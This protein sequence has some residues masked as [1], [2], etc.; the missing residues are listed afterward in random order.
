M[1]ILEITAVPFTQFHVGGGERAPSELMIELSGKEDVIGC[2][3]MMPGDTF[4]FDRHFTVPAT[5]IS[6]PPFVSIHNPLPNLHSIGSIGEFL[7][8]NGDNIEFIHIHNLRTA[9][10]TTW[11][12]LSGLMKSSYHYKII[13]TDHLARFFPFPKLT[14]QFVDYYAA[15]SKV[16][17]HQLQSYAKRPSMILPPAVSQSYVAKCKFLTFEERVID[18]LFF[19]RIL[20]QKRPEII[21][22]FTEELVNR[23]HRDIAVVIAGKDDD[24]K[25]LHDIDKMISRKGLESNIEIIRNPSDEDAITLLSSAKMHVLFSGS[26]DAYGK[27]RRHPELAPFTIIEAATAGTPSIISDFPGS[28]EQVINGITGYIIA[29]ND[30]ESAVSCIEKTIS[31]RKV[32]NAM[33]SSAREFVLSER[34]FP[35][36]TKKFIQFLDRIRNG[37]I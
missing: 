6:L 1:T 26:V 5:F 10:S 29:E 14:A 22:D 23:G 30:R 37:E 36:V 19:G 27:K 8:A 13:L 21:V 18:L 7:R 17:E 31:D 20:P 3:S 9:M 11:I 12:L 2:Y 34:T 15:V 16:S 25:Y 35:I 32:W 33:A 4:K 24:K 28:D